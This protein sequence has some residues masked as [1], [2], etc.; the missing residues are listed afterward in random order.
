MKSYNSSK[1]DSSKIDETTL[2]QEGLS[3]IP[4][5]DEMVGMHLKR[6]SSAGETNYSNLIRRIKQEIILT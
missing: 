5:I 6:H 1:R 2:K 4:K 3:K